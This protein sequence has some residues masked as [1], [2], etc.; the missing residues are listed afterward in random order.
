[1]SREL[2]GSSP[3]SWPPGSLDPARVTPD[4]IVE[5]HPDGSVARTKPAPGEPENPIDDVAAQ[6]QPGEEPATH[7]ERYKARKAAAAAKRG[8]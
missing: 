3:T 7:S 8:A 6:L 5:L 1:M 4:R 2:G